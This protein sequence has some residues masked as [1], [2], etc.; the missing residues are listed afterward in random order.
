MK[1]SLKINDFVSLK[2]RIGRLEFFVGFFLISFAAYLLNYLASKL[3]Y[4]QEYRSGYFAVK[5]LIQFFVIVWQTPFIV[6]RLHDLNSSGLWVLPYWALLPFTIEFTYLLN[7][8]LGI[9][10]NPFSK[11]VLWLSVF[12]LLMF[13]VLIVKKGNPDKNQWGYPNNQINQDAQ[14]NAGH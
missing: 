12:V 9:K 7:N 6:K 4:I 11:P 8:Y 2:G 5:V 14:L 10:I 13:L 3:L 1:L